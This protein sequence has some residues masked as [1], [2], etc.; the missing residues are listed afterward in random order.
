VK[1]CL[2]ALLLISALGAVD[3]RARL[4]INEAMVNEPGT[5]TSLEWFEIYNDLS[6]SVNLDLYV[7]W[8]YSTTDS[9][10][11]AFTG[12]NAVTLQ[13]HEYLVVCRN[14]DRYEEHY[15]DSSGVWETGVD[16]DYRIAEA[17]IRM[18]NTGGRTAVFRVNVRESLFEWPSAGPD[19]VS[20]ERTSLINDEIAV[21]I[22]PS[23]STPGRTN[24]VTTVP[25]DLAILNVAPTIFD[26]ATDLAFRIK[27]TGETSIADATLSLYHID[28]TAQNLLG[29]LIASESVGS[30]DTGYT[31]ILIGRYFFPER[32]QV[33]AA[34]L[35][36]DDRLENNRFD[37]VAPGGDFPPVILNEF[38]PDPEMPLTSEWV[39]V[40]NIS[41]D[42]INLQGWS[43]GDSLSL[44]LISDEPLWLPVDSYYVLVQDS[45]DFRFFYQTYAGLL[46]Q[47]VGWPALNNVTADLV[48]LVDDFSLEADR[49]RYGR[50]KESNYTWSRGETP[51]Y[52][53]TWDRADSVGG[54]P[55]RRN[56][57]SFRITGS[58]GLEVIATPRIISPDGDGI[59]DETSLLMVGP[60]A[61][62]YTLKIFDRAGRPVRT[63]LENDVRLSGE[64]FV[65][66]GR[67]DS[68]ERLPVGIY[69]IFCEAAGVETFKTTV[70]IAR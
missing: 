10:S 39:E 28:S 68:G 55:G 67:N 7:F 9:G 59:D 17:P 52:E 31:V 12:T 4:V 16:G 24:S 37:F 43:L 38:L 5:E 45:S 69:V 66:D 54:S 61:D 11:F 22:D 60:E 3:A 34:V 58:E 65:W 42:S 49:Y 62:S 51:P 35:P 32:H 29:E 20:W 57:V 6:G 40:K 44:V 70:V 21:C 8:W 48:R 30:L 47:P 36:D 26:G 53:D 64:P 33:L 14:A 2:I 63:F 19:G 56:V 46:H 50:G 1:H 25:V 18:S 23:G 41:G 27:N 15:G 13:S